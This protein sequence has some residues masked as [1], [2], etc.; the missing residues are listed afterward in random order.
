M[1]LLLIKKGEKSKLEATRAKLPELTEVYLE[2]LIV[3]SQFQGSPVQV[4]WT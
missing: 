3:L 1:E 4:P 2:K